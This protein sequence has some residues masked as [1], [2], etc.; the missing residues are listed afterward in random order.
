M[1]RVRQ[2]RTPKMVLVVTA[3]LVLAACATA[4]FSPVLPD[5]DGFMSRGTTQEDNR[6]T[7]T[8]AVPSAEEVEELIGIDLANSKNNVSFPLLPGVW[9]ELASRAVMS[10]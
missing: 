8:A 5:P 7:V 3:A 4:A 9:K 2:Q 6:V 1:N 10:S